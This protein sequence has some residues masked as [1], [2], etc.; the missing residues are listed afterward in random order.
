[1]KMSISGISLINYL[2]QMYGTQAENSTNS[3]YHGGLSTAASGSHKE[4]DQ[5]ATDLSALWEALQAGNLSSAQSYLSQL[6]EDMEAFG[7]NASDSAQSTATAASTNSVND[8][9]PMAN[10]FSALKDALDSGD[11]TSAQNIFSQI[12]QHMQPPP[13]PP[14]ANDSDSSQSTAN[15]SSTDAVNDSNPLANDLSVLEDALNSGDLTSAQNI[16]AQIMQHIQ[17]PP[18]PPDVNT[19]DSTQNAETAA[20][21]VSSIDLDQLLK[22][23]ASIMSTNTSTLDT[24]T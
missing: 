16:F 7:K 9:N 3:Q 8:S 24:S 21:S 11:L 23:L 20:S 5:I 4:K 2:H 12:M 13:P 10:D 19:S 22:M 17:P 1:M 6:Q 18:P 15:S 14:E